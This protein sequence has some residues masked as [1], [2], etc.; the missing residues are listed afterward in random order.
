MTQ[1]LGAAMHGEMLTCRHGAQMIQIRALNSADEGDAEA[2]SQERVFSIG[3]LSA[4]P[5]RIAED[6]DVW[7]PESE[8]VKDAMIAFA[9]CL[10]VL[11]ARLSG[12][13]ITHTVHDGRVPGRGHTDRLRKHG[14]VAGAGDP[15]KGLVPG[16][17]VGDSE[18]RNCSGPVFKLCRFFI[19]SHAAHQI[20]SAFTG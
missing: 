14:G 18:P 17:V 8:A 20:M 4:A 19:Q 1:L 12:D 9:L 13:D 16:L 7:R 5:T 3:F 11:G 15:V 6:V 10:V 2:A